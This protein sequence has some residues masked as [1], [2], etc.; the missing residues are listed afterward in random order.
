[1]CS[2]GAVTT[3]ARLDELLPSV[4]NQDLAF[5]GLAWSPNGSLIAVAT[6]ALDHQTLIILSADTGAVRGQQAG[7]FI[8][9]PFLISRSWSPDGRYLLYWVQPV[10][11]TQNEMG[12]LRIL[13]TRTDQVV[14]LP[15]V[16]LWDWSPDGKWL[17]MAIQ[18]EAML[19]AAPD[20]ASIRW[21]NEGMDCI[22]VAWRPGIR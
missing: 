1:M 4:S 14:A 9:M 18:N 3:L 15:G 20:F 22:T 13:D 19:L 21:L 10:S 5:G 16:G 11:Q 8:P 2:N 12:E 17:A 7:T 6:E